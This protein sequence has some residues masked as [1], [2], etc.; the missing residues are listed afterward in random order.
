MLTFCFYSGNTVFGQIWSKKS[1]LLFQ[2]KISYLD[3]LEYAEFRSDVHFLCFRVEL[4]FLGKIAPRN[5][6]FYFKLKFHSETNMNMHNLV[7]ILTFHF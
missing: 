7:V 1:K 3:Y 4:P 5:R 6:N 2:A